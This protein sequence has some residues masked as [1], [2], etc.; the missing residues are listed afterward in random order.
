[1]K[2]IGRCARVLDVHLT[3]GVYRVHLVAVEDAI[4]NPGS[5]V[6]LC[7]AWDFV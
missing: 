1:M 7:E 3:A 4:V 5:D 2:A 6:P